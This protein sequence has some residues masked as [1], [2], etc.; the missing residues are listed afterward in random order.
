MMMMMIVFRLGLLNGKIF[1]DI[2]LGFSSIVNSN[3]YNVDEVSGWLW[4]L[5]DC[6]LHKLKNEAT[7][8]RIVQ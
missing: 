8:V 2:T 4:N 7:A 1:E 3:Y 6:W 5:S